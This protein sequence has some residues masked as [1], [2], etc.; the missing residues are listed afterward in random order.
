MLLEEGNVLVH[1]ARK[2]GDVNP[3]DPIYFPG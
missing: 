3:M 2:R 1:V